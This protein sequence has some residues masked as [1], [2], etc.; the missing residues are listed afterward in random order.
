M[1]NF[2]QKNL[3]LVNKNNIINIKFGKKISQNIFE[4]KILNNKIIEN[5]IQNLKK[6]TK[7][8]KV[9]YQVLEFNYLDNVILKQINK[10]HNF[11]YQ[12]SDTISEQKTFLSIIKINNDNQI[13]E[14]PPEYNLISKYY[15]TVINIQSILEIIIKKYQNYFTVD[16]EI[17]K[18]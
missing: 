1:D 8:K 14:C 3:P 5:I 2:L 13:I 11:S 4:T 7:F 10:L 12:V 9:Y 18:P 16:F 17:K 15:K 6:E